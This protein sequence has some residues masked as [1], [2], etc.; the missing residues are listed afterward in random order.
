MEKET[1]KQMP[2]PNEAILQEMYE[3]SKMV[4]SAGE[5]YVVRGARVSCSG[6]RD[7]CVLNLP[8]THGAV[9]ADNRPLIT[10]YDTTINNVKGFG[11]CHA[12]LHGNECYPQLGLWYN[13]VDGVKDIEFSDR[14]ESAVLV[15]AESQ[16]GL[17][18]RVR[19]ETSGQ[20]IPDYAGDFTDSV[21]IVEDVKGNY[22]GMSFF[23]HFHADHSGVYN[24]GI[25]ADSIEEPV[26]G[27]VF[28]YK[29]DYI[30][31]HRY[32]V[33]DSAYQLKEYKYSIKFQP[34]LWTTWVDLVL[35]K[36]TDYYFE[37]DCP[38]ISRYSYKIMGNLD[39]KK[40]TVCGFAS[41]R[42]DENYTENHKYNFYH[43]VAYENH[44]MTICFKVY[45]DKLFMKL[46]RM[47]LVQYHY[48]AT[49]KLSKDVEDIFTSII[50][51]LIGLFTTAG[52]IAVT[53]IDTILSMIP[54]DLEKIVSIIDSYSK[55]NALSDD[56][57]G[58]V[59]T[60]Y[61]LT[62]GSDMPR[63]EIKDDVWKGE[64]IEGYKYLIGGFQTVDHTEELDN[65]LD[66]VH[67]AV[68]KMTG[69]FDK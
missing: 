64:Y 35:D 59:L 43:N 14:K 32:L 24:L 33:Y 60:F 54:S 26:T 27:S 22:R 55:K 7:Y 16:C 25:H 66:E 11:E 9:T 42:V 47:L 15:G 10:V 58:T 12:R 18:G 57:R 40:D 20:T 6:G 34:E 19:I 36:G 53:V 13:G 5:E 41:W 2:S 28:M 23:G 31:F 44:V 62:C 30:L 50:N 37:I 49:H 45:M 39:K 8:R 56:A 63:Y 67:D 38:G 65:A 61:D 68:E 21:P 1:T 52:G 48:N 46:F 4:S 29:S 51:T 17:G 69:T 3:Y